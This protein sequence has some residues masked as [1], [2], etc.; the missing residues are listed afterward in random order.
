MT[1]T[2]GPLP[3]ILSVIQPQALL[4][5]AEGTITGAGSHLPDLLRSAVGRKLAEVL[6]PVDKPGNELEGWVLLEG[7]GTV[8]QLRRI[9]LPGGEQVLVVHTG[10]NGTAAI[11]RP[12]KG[13][14]GQGVQLLQN[15][16]AGVLIID[17]ESRIRWANQRF[18]E[19]F[20]FGMAEIVGR[21]AGEF[22]TA[23]STDPAMVSELEHA[24]HTGQ[25]FVMEIENATKAGTTRWVEVRG[26]PVLDEQG[27][28]SGHLILYEDIDARKRV[29]ALDERERHVYEAVLKR[30]GDGIYI[31]D[32]VTGQD[33]WLA[34]L[35]RLYGLVP[36]A[37]MP[38]PGDWLNR[39]P[40]EVAA[41][42]GRI[43]EAYREGRITSHV[44]EFP[45]L[46]YDGTT[47]WLLNRGQVL[48]RDA[49]GR[50]RTLLGVLSDIDAWKKE[51]RKA[52]HEAD[53]YRSALQGTGDGV[54]ELDLRTMKSKWAPGLVRLLGLPPGAPEPRPHDWHKRVPAATA[55]QLAQL[56]DAYRQGQISEHAL[57]YPIEGFDGQMR[58]VMDRGQ[59][60]ERDEGGL[61]VRLV[62]VITDMTTL[63]HTEQQLAESEE[64][65]AALLR[66]LSQP[67][68]LE[69]DKHIVRLVNPGFCELIG[70]QPQELIG[71]R[72]GDMLG[73]DRERLFQDPDTVFRTIKQ[74]L[75]E[76][77]PVEGDRILLRDG[78]VL[79]RDYTPVELKDRSIGHLWIHR[80]VTERE[81]LES[82]ARRSKDLLNTVVS[83]VSTGIMVDVDGRIHVANEALCTLF[84]TG[85]SS[86]SIIGLD[87]TKASADLANVMAEPAA[88]LER[89]VQLKR[90][91]KPV[92]GDLQHLKD[93]RILE[94]DFEPIDLAD[95]SRVNVFS[96]RDVSEHYRLLHALQLSADQ[97]S[98][99]IESMGAGLLME[100]PEGR[101]LLTNATLIDQ[102]GLA[103][104]DAMDHTHAGHRIHPLMAGQMTDGAAYLEQVNQVVNSGVP[105][106]TVPLF[107]RDGRVLECSHRPMSFVHGYGHL[108]T[109]NDI[110]ERHRLEREK[111]VAVQ[112]RERLLSALAEATG[113]LV[114]TADVMSELPAIFEEIGMATE[115]HRVY[116]FENAI[117]PSGDTIASSQRIE[118]NSGVAE[119]QINNPDLQDMPVELF[120]EFI[121]PMINGESFAR[122][123]RDVQQEL[124][125]TTLAA[126]GIISILILPITVRGRFWGFIGFDDCV[127]ERQWTA[128]ELAVLRSLSAAIAA[129]VERHLLT[130]ERDME[131]RAERTV[132]SLTRRLMGLYE[133]VDVYTAVVEEITRFLELEHCSF[134]ATHQKDGTYHL[135]DVHTLPGRGSVH[136]VPEGVTHLIDM[137]LKEF[138]PDQ[139][140]PVRLSELGTAGR[141]THAIMPVTTGRELLGFISATCTSNASN[142]ELLMRVLER[143]A[144]AVAVK[145]MQLSAFELVRQQDER[146]QRIINN[147]QLGLVEV[148]QEHRITAA[149]QKFADMCGYPI[150]TILGRNLLAFPGLEHATTLFEEKRELRR[151]GVSDAFELKVWN[152][153]GEQRHW[154]ISGAPSLDPHG[155]HIGSVNVILDITDRKRME[156]DLFDANVMARSSL[157]AKELFLA[158]MSHEMRTPM[159]VVLG[160]CDALIRHEARPE[161]LDQ[162]RTVHQATRNLLALTNDILQ[163]SRAASGNLALHPKP[164]SLADLVTHI[165]KLFLPQARAK[166]LKLKTTIGTSREAVH[167][168]DPQRLDQVLVNLVGNAIKF[169]T[170]GEV[171]ITLKGGVVQGGMQRVVLTVSDTGPGMSASFM[172]HVFEPF[173][174]DPMLQGT[175]IEGSGLGLSICKHI[176]DLMQ[177]SILVDSTP[178]MGTVVNVGLDLPLATTEQDQ[179]PVLIERTEIM[180]PKATVLLAEDSAFNRKVVAAMLKGQPIELL[181]VEH[182]AAALEL[183]GH[184]QVDLVLLDLRMP[185]MDGH[186][187]L[188]I[189]RGTLRDPVPVLTLTAGG[190][191]TEQKKNAGVPVE[192]PALQKPFERHDLLR[193]MADLLH[194]SDGQQQDGPRHAV[195]SARWDRASLINTVGDDPTVVNEIID[196]FR[197]EAPRTLDE[198][199]HAARAGDRATMGALAHRMR[200]SLRMLGITD[201]QD[202]LDQLIA[203]GRD[204]AGVERGPGL[205]AVVRRVVEE[206]LTELDT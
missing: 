32:L 56:G 109:Y 148:D 83:S 14:P 90:E 96:Y 117:D 136:V 194:P 166:G 59:V 80:D 98:Q 91:R 60:L 127:K 41:E 114:L 112:A 174:R 180:L 79:E 126:Q 61:P 99:V 31:H 9:D 39:L 71:R 179:Q 149:N 175:E 17:Q 85:C 23:P 87:C 177:G 43:A 62:G 188:S 13:L 128:H 16:H 92:K 69:D 154:L 25:P 8:V 5:D 139:A 183:M 18:V 12:F 155:Q 193:H 7:P 100:D 161:Q 104:A 182:G 176:I 168:V 200:P 89:I 54:W 19:L 45:F 171:S 186:E 57:E 76:R 195:R 20:G 28:L 146:Y 67:L 158:N 52:E 203:I 130:Q 141:S 113:R 63:K 21:H 201:A 147:M 153:S 206:A 66:S 78:R 178:G 106:S 27:S 140:K 81:R 2:S 110:T 132:N 142:D 1:T 26:E 189:L 37:P 192:G 143:S 65:M 97:L 202:A 53:L 34:G 48:D 172:E 187:F 145:L 190:T 169:T 64:R 47:R 199:T 72:A 165:E 152:A 33:Q 36:N 191:A 75:V 173:S 134:H 35:R 105:F 144:D 156:Q 159:N 38:P 68:M 124:L 55:Q 167:L 84:G 88:F 82:D 119:P 86:S 116:L 44:L 196:V 121:G 162:L 94:R 77:R 120:E 135:L 122:A 74:R 123:V 3:S 50:P 51:Q 102:F 205:V 197:V 93:G 42:V 111:Q 101:T 204:S 46:G 70:R 150:S 4:V 181:E 170:T 30:T 151:N 157:Q 137:A 24:I 129:A 49:D 58:W 125:R 163:L 40:D 11:H 22:L 108:W 131:L 133:E 160:L 73:P 138:A 103:G 184:R 29:A 115:V 6:R 95:G 164:S 10:A 185:V 107:L 198:L 118:W 15:L